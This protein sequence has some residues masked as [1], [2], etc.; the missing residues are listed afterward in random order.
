MRRLVALFLL[1]IL[2]L[3]GFARAVPSAGILEEAQKE[4]LNEGVDDEYDFL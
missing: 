4:Y 1:L 2:L 3:L